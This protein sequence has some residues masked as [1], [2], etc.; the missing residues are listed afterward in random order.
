V[1]SVH[2]SPYWMR[3][4]RKTRPLI[5]RQLPAPC[6]NAGAHPSCTGIVQPGD[7][8]EIAHL[9]GKDY[10]LTRDE[11]PTLHDVGPAHRACNRAAGGRLGAAV[12]N[13]RRAVENKHMGWGSYLPGLE[14]P[15][16]ARASE[17]W[18]TW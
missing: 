18:L 16:P 15:A 13:Q 1:T 14:P 5:Q 10:V 11:Y 8:W 2:R 7:K 3:F 6:V 12:T 9:P 17:R 4:I